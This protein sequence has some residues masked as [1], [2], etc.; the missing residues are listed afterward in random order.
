MHARRVRCQQVPGADP[1][2]DCRGRFAI[3]AT[4]AVCSKVTHAD[5]EDMINLRMLRTDQARMLLE[6]S[7]Q[8]EWAVRGSGQAALQALLDGLCDLTQ[9]DALTGLANRSHFNAVLHREIDRVARSG[10]LALLLRLEIDDFRGLVE[11]RGGAAGDLLLKSVA[12]KLLEGVRPMDTVSRSGLDGFAI[13]LPDCEM[14]FGRLVAERLRAA[15][16]GNPLRL[17]SGETLSASLSVGGAFAPQWIRSSADLWLERADQQLYRARIDGGN[18][19]RLEEQLL[20]PVSSEEKNLLFGSM[21]AV[22]ADLRV[23]AVGAGRAR[24]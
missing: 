19:V 3:A 2:L 4:A 1:M 21:D 11:R 13:L 24:A 5:L 22:P 9:L 7:G 18:R 17:P 6:Q 8:A 16:E 12:K 20:G 10:Q 14:H 15:V 23:D